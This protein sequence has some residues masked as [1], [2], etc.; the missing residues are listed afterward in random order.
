MGSRRGTPILWAQPE[1]KPP[2]NIEHLFANDSAHLIGAALPLSPCLSGIDAPSRLPTYI[3]VFC[4][5]ALP[6]LSRRSDAPVTLLCA[7]EEVWKKRKRRTPK[8]ALTACHIFIYGA[9]RG[10][11]SPQQQVESERGT[12]SAVPTV[13]LMRLRQL[14]WGLFSIISYPYPNPSFSEP[15]YHAH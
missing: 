14:S 8:I 15:L 12:V 9:S 4:C 1:Q 7:A 11:A 2:L 3:Y 10:G 13:I 5:G 6:C